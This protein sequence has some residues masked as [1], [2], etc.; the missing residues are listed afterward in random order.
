VL[1]SYGS[2]EF[3]NSYS[4]AVRNLGLELRRGG[5]ASGERDAVLVHLLLGLLQT[6]LQGLALFTMVLLCVKTHSIDETASMAHVQAPAAT[7]FLD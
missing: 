7:R 2:T 4:P 1:S 3:A 5:F 6:R